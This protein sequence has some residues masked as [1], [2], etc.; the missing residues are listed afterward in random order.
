MEGGRG[1]TPTE[2]EDTVS[3]MIEIVICQGTKLSI[4]INFISS[5]V[6]EK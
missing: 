3:N 1:T 6:K 5:T 2:D 4:T